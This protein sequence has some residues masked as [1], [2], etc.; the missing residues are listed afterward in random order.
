MIQALVRYPP[1]CPC[2]SVSHVGLQRCF[3]A[4]IN[5]PLDVIKCV[6]VCVKSSFSQSV[7]Y[8]SLLSH[9]NAH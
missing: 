8:S 1:C 3:A 4:Y 5:L 2:W 6:C 9:A 7:Q